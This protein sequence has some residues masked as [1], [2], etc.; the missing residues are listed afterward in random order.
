MH[1]K[2]EAKLAE[3]IKA[4]GSVLDAFGNAKTVMNANASRHGR[5]LELHFNDRGRISSAKIL[6]Y[7]LDKTR[8]TRLSH[9]ERTYHVFY[10]LLAGTSPQERDHWGLED[11][12]DYALLASSGCYRLPSGPFS[13]DSI[14]FSELRASLKSL[15]FKPKNI[16]SMFQLLVTI[17]LLGNLQFSG[18]DAQDVSAFIHNIQTLDQAARMLGV[19]WE[20][21]SQTLTNKMSYVRKDLYTRLLIATIVLPANLHLCFWTDLFHQRANMRNLTPGRRTLSRP[22]STTP[23]LKSSPISIARTTGQFHASGWFAELF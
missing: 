1:S 16:S 3:Q 15:V 18:A 5:Y 17:L 13:D 20:G 11:P 23:Y 10:Q 19:T 2:R 7:G 14:A 4:L 21:L 22:N 6:T 9:E 12:L 8:L